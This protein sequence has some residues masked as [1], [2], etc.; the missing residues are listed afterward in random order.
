MQFHPGLYGSG[1]AAVRVASR[2]AET[3]SPSNP[4]ASRTPASKPAPKPRTPLATDEA[5]RTPVSSLLWL[6]VQWVR[7]ETIIVTFP[8]DKS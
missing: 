1:A 4:A 5:S 6:C 8:L 3:A 7:I 2:L